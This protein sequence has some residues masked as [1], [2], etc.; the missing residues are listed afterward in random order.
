MPGGIQGGLSGGIE[1]AQGWEALLGAVAESPGITLVIG[2]VDTGKSC[3]CAFLA[4]SLAEGG[5]KTAVVDADVGQSDIGPPTTIGLGEVPGRLSSLSE[6]KE[7]ALHFVGHCSPEGFLLQTLVG[8]VRLAVEALR[9]GFEQVVVDTTGLVHGPGRALKLAK[10]TLLQPRHIV[11]I[12]RE[13]ELSALRAWLPSACDAKVHTLR[14]S[15][16]VRERSREERRERRKALFA[17]Y[18]EGAKEVVYK[19]VVVRGSS[20]G[21]GR[22]LPGHMLS[23]LGERLSTKPKYAERD[24]KELR[25]VAGETFDLTGLGELAGSFGVEK[26]RV[27]SP[28][29]WKNLVVGLTERGGFCLGVG[30]LLEV[31]WAEG[32]FLVLTPRSVDPSRVGVIELGALRIKSDG[33][34]LGKVHPAEL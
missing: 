28:S 19:G 31:D 9:M 29:R 3:L 22:P 8:T 30:I 32:A 17:S 16:R 13:E 26:V 24:C 11:F 18:F 25:V 15:P 27:A 33:T 20:F 6:C 5:F 2:E 21:H 34:E 12:E 4:G 14:P 10:A 23:Y 7:L 1:P